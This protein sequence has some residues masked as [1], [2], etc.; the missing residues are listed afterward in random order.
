[1]INKKKTI[2]DSLLT[3]KKITTAT[4]KCTIAI[5]SDIVLLEVSSTIN[6]LLNAVDDKWLIFP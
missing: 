1:M 4:S 5:I 2:I 6:G 3:I